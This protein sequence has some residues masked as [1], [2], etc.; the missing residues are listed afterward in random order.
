MSEP[1]QGGTRPNTLG[2]D[3]TGECAAAKAAAEAADS[4]YLAA[5]SGNPGVGAPLMLPDPPSGYGGYQTLPVVGENYGTP[6]PAQPAQV[7][8]DHG[9]IGAAGRPG[10]AAGPAGDEDPFIGGA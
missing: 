9:E 4:S 7:A 10:Y 3:F 2:I 5:A 8:A 1:A 6:P